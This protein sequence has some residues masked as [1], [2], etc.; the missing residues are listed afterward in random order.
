MHRGAVVI[1]D[2]VANMNIYSRVHPY[3]ARVE[4]E[5]QAL[6]GRELSVGRFEIEGEGLFYQVQRYESKA[7]SVCHFE[8]HRRYIDVQCVLE[9]RETAYV[10]QITDVEPTDSYDGERD[11]RFYRDA[12][13]SAIVLKPGMFALFFP[14]DAHKPCCHYDE[15]QVNILKVVF[16]LAI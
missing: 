5:L 3:I 11:I 16:K 1:Y 9:G 8:S 7:P 13:S 12:E 14:Q 6:G 10:T 4:Q 15:N 2:D